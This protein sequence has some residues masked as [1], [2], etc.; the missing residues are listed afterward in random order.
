MNFYTY[1]LYVFME[2]IDKLKKLNIKPTEFYVIC[3]N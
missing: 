3:N 2:K 1:K